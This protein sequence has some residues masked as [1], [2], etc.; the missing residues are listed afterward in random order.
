[1]KEITIEYAKFK[2]MK[3]KMIN[4]LVNLEDMKTSEGSKTSNRT[5]LPKSLDIMIKDLTD[6]L[7]LAVGKV[8]GSSEPEILEMPK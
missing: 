2:E 1:M 5:D 6:A 3:D 4:V 8:H 7:K